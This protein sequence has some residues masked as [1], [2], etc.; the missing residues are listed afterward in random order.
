M[1]IHNSAR[2]SSRG[3]IYIYILITLFTLPAC[4]PQKKHNII[5]SEDMLYGEWELVGKE[6]V[7]YPN[8]E[9]LK[10][11]SAVLHSQADTI[12]RFTF[13]IRNDSLVLVD[14]NGN[15]HVNKI[16]ELNDKTVVLDGI[17]DV[18]ENRPT[19]DETYRHYNLLVFDL[20]LR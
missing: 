16:C 19:K 17:A 2:L 1:A 14:I 11:S 6:Q 3:N 5:V 7:N 12:Y 18:H 10:D 13:F 9:F 20:L 15:K 4:A 8:I